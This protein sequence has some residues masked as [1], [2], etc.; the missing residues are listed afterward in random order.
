MALSDRINEARPA[1]ICG[2]PCSVGKLLATLEGDE[3]ASFKI[4]LGTK[5]QRGWTAPD[6]Y[7]AVI[8]EGHTI[9]FQTIN[10]HRGGRCRCPKASA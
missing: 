2:T 4:M 6:I 3:L 9:G 10:K 8:A 7:D 1:P 5:E